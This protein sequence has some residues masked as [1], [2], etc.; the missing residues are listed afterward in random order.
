[1]LGKWFRRTPMLALEMECRIDLRF[2]GQPGRQVPRL[3]WWR[4]SDFSARGRAFVQTAVACPALRRGASSD[5]RGRAVHIH[6]FEGAGALSRVA[7]S[8]RQKRDCAMSRFEQTPQMFTRY[9]SLCM[10]GLRV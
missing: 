5:S 9:S 10:A 4:L 8:R 6:S 3:G 2:P 7:G 1:M